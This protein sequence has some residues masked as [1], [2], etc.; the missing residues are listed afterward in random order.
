[1]KLRMAGSAVQDRRGAARVSSSGTP[2]ARNGVMSDAASIDSIG[3][4]GAVGVVSS[5]ARE[6]GLAISAARGGRLFSA[7]APAAAFRF[8]RDQ[9]ARTPSAW[10]I[11]PSG[12]RITARQSLWI[13][14]V[15]LALHETR[16][17]RILGGEGRDF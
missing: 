13:G 4:R 7:S 2:G 17:S 14:T 3:G 11:V 10:P 5:A 8:R 15:A 16:S 9:R 12:L 1:M 6:I